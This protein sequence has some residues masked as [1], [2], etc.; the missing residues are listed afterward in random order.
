MNHFI[1]TSCMSAV[2]L[3]NLLEK[4]APLIERKDTLMIRAIPPAERLD[5]TLRYLVTGDSY[6]SL[7]YLFRIPANTISQ[8]IPEVCRAIYDVIK[9]EHLKTPN[10]E[11]EWTEVA[12]EFEKKWNFPNCIGAIDGKYVNVKAPEIVEVC[13]SITNIHTA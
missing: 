3:D 10:T 1:R 8:I 12:D 4:V 13:T 2:D 9:E 11:A 6:K 7:L 5:V